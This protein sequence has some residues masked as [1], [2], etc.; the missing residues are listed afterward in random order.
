MATISREQLTGLLIN[1]GISGE[2]LAKLVAIAGRES[3]YKT[4]AHRTDSDPAKLSG[5]R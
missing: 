5:D 1:A 3:G 2:A 4:D